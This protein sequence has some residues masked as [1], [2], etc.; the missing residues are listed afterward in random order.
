MSGIESMNRVEWNRNRVESSSSEIEI[1]M[2]WSGVESNRVE[3]NRIESS[4]SS[5]MEWN[6]IEWN[7]V[8]RVNGIE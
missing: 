8:N 7:R 2:E 5:G 1:G 6:G 4:E 3:S